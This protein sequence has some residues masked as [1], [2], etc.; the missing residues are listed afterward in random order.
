MA[1]TFDDLASEDWLIMQGDDITEPTIGYRDSTRRSAYVGPLVKVMIGCTIENDD[2]VE[3][4][5]L[6]GADG[7]N[8][9]A[10]ACL[11]QFAELFR[12]ITKQYAKL[13]VSES[14]EYN[15]FV[16][17]LKDRVDWICAT[18]DD[19]ADEICE[20]S[21]PVGFVRFTAKKAGRQ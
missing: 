18:I 20:D 2:G 5:D 10:I 3:C 1:T 11:P 21:G 9:Y 16:D 6:E 4:L 14:D 17:E 12:W 8:L 19:R 13:G 7:R 15:K